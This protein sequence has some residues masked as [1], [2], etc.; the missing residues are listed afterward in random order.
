MTVSKMVVDTV[1]QHNLIDVYRIMLYPLAL[2]S[3]KRF[4]RERDD[5][6]T[7]RLADARTTGTGVVVLTYERY[8]ARASTT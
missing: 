7:L 4:F 1:M 5:K 2:A 3:G 6:T 8:G